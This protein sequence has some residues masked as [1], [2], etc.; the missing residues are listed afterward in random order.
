[1]KLVFS[2]ALLASAM[3]VSAMLLSSVSSVS[4][5]SPSADKLQT[6]S[7]Q[8]DPKVW[9]SVKK[10]LDSSAL[11]KSTSVLNGVR[12]YTYTLPSGS[13]LSLSEPAGGRSAISPQLSVGGCGLLRLCV[14]LNRGDQLIVAAGSF[15]ALTSIIC[16]AGPAAC[17]VAVAV[18]AATFQAISNR[19]YIC[20]HYMVVEI[21]FSPGTV[22]NCY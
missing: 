21:L 17:V 4:A 12:T 1:M 20:P 18:A 13:A 14:W 5:A 9:A 2:R 6:S 15:G 3:L 8:M 16:L 10:A 11:T 22:R 19:G 7:G